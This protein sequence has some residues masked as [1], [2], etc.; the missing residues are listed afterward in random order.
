[1]GMTHHSGKIQS[2][3]NTVFAHRTKAFR[4]GEQNF[5]SSITHL[6]ASDQCRKAMVSNGCLCQD[7]ICVPTGNYFLFFSPSFLRQNQCK[8]CTNSVPQCVLPLWEILPNKIIMVRR[9]QI[10]YLLIIGS[11]DRFSVLYQY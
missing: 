11:S 10:L 7:P 3:Q 4:T 9:K 8:G 1:M 5:S 2:F 6:I